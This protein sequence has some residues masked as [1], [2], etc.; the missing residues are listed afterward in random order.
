MGAA[1][2]ANI[3]VSLSFALQALSSLVAPASV[4][5]GRI[6]FNLNGLNL[7][8]WNTVYV[9]QFTLF[10]GSP[11]GLAAVLVAG[12]SLSSGTP[13]YYKVTATAPNGALN[14]NGA[15]STSESTPSNEQTVTPTPGNQTAALTWTALTGA[16][17]YNIYRGTSPGA[18]NLLVGTSTTTSFND[19]GFAGSSQSPPGSNPGFV[20]FAIS[21]FTDLDGN[22]QTM[23][24][25]LGFVA[26]TSGGATATGLLRPGATH[27]LTWCFQGGTS[28]GINLNTPGTEVHSDGPAASGTAVSAG[29]ADTLRIVAGGS[30]TLVVTLGI[31]GK[32]S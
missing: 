30:G 29:S 7:T 5:N 6:S 2:Q 1:T 27:G 22:T 12:G 8:T 3:S 21:S 11:T 14:P 23:A 18:E 16:T 13:Y 19:T 20:E 10:Q 9:A 28:G 15:A 24:H 4:P 26:V 31:I 25:V 32:N 17:S